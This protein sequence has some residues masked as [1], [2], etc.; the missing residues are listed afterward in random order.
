MERPVFYILDVFAEQKYSGNQLAVFCCT[1]DISDIEMQQ[2]ARE[3]NYSETTFI[4]S[5]EQR[6]GGFDV[7]IF[8]PQKE[9][10]FAGHPSLGTAYV[11]R[12][13]IIHEPVET[14]ILNLKSGQIPV[15]FSSP[16]SSSSGVDNRNLL[17]MKQPVPSFGRLFDIEST[18]RVLS[19]DEDDFDGR[20]P[21][22]T[23]STGFP[24]TIVPLKSLDSLKRLRLDRSEYFSWIKNEWGKAVLVFCPETN[25]Y[26]NDLSVRVFAD[27]YGIPEDPATGSAN[28]C[29]A[30]YLIK[31]RYFG[32]SS[33]NLRI[34]QGYDMGRPSLIFLKAEDNKGVMDVSVG[35]TVVK[36]AKG[37]FF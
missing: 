28:G 23:V 21:V 29:L 32:E 2:I 25:N 35:G 31:Y 7:R 26:M 24:F 5:G 9:I 34:E 36:I 27:Y 16:V 30:A 37:E 17:W 33:I 11:I 10:P 14:V 8:T 13:E 19:L 15:S 18:A 20:F 22:A 12:H 6:N 3:I 4:L 1:G